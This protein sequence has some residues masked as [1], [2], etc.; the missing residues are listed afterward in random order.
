MSLENVKYVNVFNHY[1]LIQDRKISNFQ[2]FPLLCACTDTEYR[3][4]KN[5]KNAGKQKYMKQ[6]AT[7]VIKFCKGYT[8]GITRL[9]TSVILKEK[10]RYIEVSARKLHLSPVILGLKVK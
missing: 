1:K 9:L 6:I 8:L 4:V 3:T 10:L 5:A 7:K 2:N